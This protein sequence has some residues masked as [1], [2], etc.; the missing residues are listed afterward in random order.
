[1]L[2]GGF[3]RASAAI[4]AKTKLQHD[5]LNFHENGYNISCGITIETAFIQKNRV[6]NTILGKLLQNTELALLQ[7]VCLS[8]RN[9]E[10]LQTISN[11]TVKNL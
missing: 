10:I 6:E 3:S 11:F 5:W 1:M 2:V 8:P 4:P 7:S 9:T